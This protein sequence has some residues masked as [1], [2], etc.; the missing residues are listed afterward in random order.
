MS[1]STCLS[2]QFSF[3]YS[4]HV[5]M[6]RVSA[7]NVGMQS[8]HDFEEFS[9]IRETLLNALPIFEGK[10][11]LTLVAP[12]NLGGVLAVAHLEAACIDAG[13]PYRRKFLAGDDNLQ[14]N[15]AILV[16]DSEGISSSI[17]KDGC[18]C[19][20]PMEMEFDLGSSGLRRNGVMEEVCQSA[21]LASMVASNG[22]L[23]KRL[24]PWALAGSWLRNTMDNA[25]DAQYSRI[26]ELLS[27]EGTIRLVPMVEVEDCDLLSLSGISESLLQRMKRHWP[28][29]D[30][31]QRSSAMSDL[32][33]PALEADSPSTARIEELGWLRVLSADWNSDMATMLGRIQR[34][35]PNDGLGVHCARLVDQLLSTGKL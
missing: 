25:F 3:R 5:E 31:A 20:N 18:L 24:R 7:R 30:L 19:L 1:F 9:V 29:M 2:L 27:Q 13:I 35:W 26:K 10:D 32:M 16:Q 33:L 15:Q 22:A 28:K 21:I 12:C 34:D 17:F 11:T 23:V 4:P 14:F 8:W 6:P